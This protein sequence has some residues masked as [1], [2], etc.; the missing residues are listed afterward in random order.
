MNDDDE[1]NSRMLCHLCIG[2]EYLADEVSNKGDNATCFYCDR[3]GRCYSIGEIAERID[4]A[5]E[6]HFRRTSDQPN[7][8]QFSL[9]RDKESNYEWE[10]DGVPV[11]DA[12]EAAAD[13]PRAAAEDVQVIL[14]DQYSDLEKEAI[15]EETEF[16]GETY[17]EE[18]PASDGVWRESWRSFEQSL[19]TE[20]RF[21]SRIAAGHLASIF[22]DIGSMATADGKPLIRL[23]GPGT[24]LASVYRA[25]VF[26]SD[27]ALVNALC[28][29]DTELGSPPF[30]FSKAGRM[31]AA[32]IS[33][34]Y[35]S[36]D[37][38]GAIAE[39]RPPVGSQVAVAEFQIL[40]PLKI[41][42]LTALVAV[43]VTGSIFDRAY[44]ARMERAVFLRSLCQ[45]IT[46]PVMPDDE[47]FEYLATQAVAD[48]L[49]T[50]LEE[51]LD[52]ILYPSA[53]VEGDILNIVLFQKSARV[54][55]MDIPPGAVI[56]G[57]TVQFTDE[58]WETDYWVSERVPPAALVAEAKKSL[59]SMFDRDWTIG[60][61]DF[62]D[63][64]DVREPSLRVIA[65]SIKVH[66]VQRIAVTV[67]S[68]AVRRDRWEDASLKPPAPPEDPF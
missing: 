25:R 6:Q 4:S 46:K 16:S 28:R 17:Y 66:V 49:S 47:V 19:K 12:I 67:E 11:T 9:L 41:L 39:V 62:Y 32:G 1:L 51:P 34:F 55:E 65:Q 57:N 45:R 29:P 37:P 52:G 2:E 15:G 8:W 43:S 48:F 5:F 40:K 31:N 23:I 7:D 54:E 18:R 27:D 36:T 53:Q 3:D 59:S 56:R 13:I 21:F 22:D 14:S 68:H 61:T 42:D 33:V 10:R 63:N 38:L 44:G 50:E 30:R 35:G 20:A 24:N 64:R 26:Q 60:A 58:G